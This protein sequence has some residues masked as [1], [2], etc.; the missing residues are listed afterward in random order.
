MD[1]NTKNEESREGEDE[2]HT[3]RSKLLA[4]EKLPLEWMK[5]FQEKLQGE[6]K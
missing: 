3:R 1:E 2:E 6:T 4:I 5:G